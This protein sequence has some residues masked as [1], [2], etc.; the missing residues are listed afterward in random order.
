MFF[1]IVYLISISSV[2]AYSLRNQIAD[3]SDKVINN[4]VQ[5]TLIDKYINNLQNNYNKSILSLQNKS[6]EFATSV[7]MLYK[8]QANPKELLLVENLTKTETLNTFVIITYWLKSTTSIIL[9]IYLELD[10][11]K[12]IIKK[13]NLAKQ[14]VYLLNK[15]LSLNQKILNNIVKTNSITTSNDINK[16]R[17]LLK[18]N[19]AIY[20]NNNSLFAEIDKPLLTKAD[21]KADNIFIKE[22]KGYMLWPNEGSIYSSFNS[23]KSYSLTYY[24]I[25]LMASSGSKIYAPASGEVI[26][27]D[28]VG[29]YN[30]VIMIKHSP[31]FI[32]IISGNFVESVKLSQN[33]KKGEIIGNVNN[34]S[35]SPIYLEIDNQSTPIDPSTWLDRKV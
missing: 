29:R 2:K 24:G 34:I 31:S 18:Y 25:V 15:Q 17:E 6:T 7:A 30:N 14:K 3:L 22:N 1:V 23:S 28:L 9:K 20:V 27:C 21:K 13:L 11:T 10:S 32:T 12:E 5:L 35:N 4:K 33:V 16:T 8:L 26:F 19:Q